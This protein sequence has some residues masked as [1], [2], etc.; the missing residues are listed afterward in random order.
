MGLFSFLGFGNISIKNALRKGAV[1]IDVRTGSEYDRG[2]VPG[3]INIPVDRISVSIG[4]IKAINRPVVLVCSSGSRSADALK[5]L[6]GRG[7]EAY[8]G[9]NWEDVVKLM[10]HF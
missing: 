10:T 5:I 9:G 8:N 4:R 7:I 6:K 3:S 1:V 2:R